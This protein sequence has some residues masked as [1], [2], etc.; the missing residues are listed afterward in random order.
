MA[1]VNIQEPAQTRAHLNVPAATPARYRQNFIR[2]AVCEL[3]FPTLYALEGPKPPPSFALALRKEYPIQQLMESVNVGMGPLS[4]ANVHSFKSKQQKWTVTLNA[5]SLVLETV[6]YEYFAEFKRRLAVILTAAE[7]VI[8]SDF[9]TRVGLRYIN[10]LP[11]AKGELHN[12]VNPALVGP[13]SDGVYGDVTEH[14]GRVL[15]STPCGGYMLQHGLV[16]DGSGVSPQYSL[17]FDFSCED[18]PFAETLDIVQ[19]LH[20]QEF[21]MFQWALGP[22]AKTHLGHS[23]LQGIS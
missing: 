18:V 21:S 3:R 8:D 16:I 17:D 13:L 10:T 23:T 9:F 5:A 4:R 19:K 15:G 2:Q 1:V 20:D 6:S 7:R 11:Y 12:W 14:S 22:A